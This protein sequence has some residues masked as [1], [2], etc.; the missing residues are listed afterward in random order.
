MT[1]NRKLSAPEALQW[2]LV[3]AVVPDDELAARMS[4]LAAGYAASLWLVALAHGLLIGVGCSA[5]FGPADR[6]N[7]K[8]PIDQRS[9]QSTESGQA[10]RP[11]DCPPLQRNHAHPGRLHG[12]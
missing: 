3:S 7:S 6:R 1:S 5:S 11:A 10:S 9:Q 12:G 2:G 8:R 4:E